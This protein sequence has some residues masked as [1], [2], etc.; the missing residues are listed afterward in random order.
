VI[1]A[2]LMAA[3]GAFY[4]LRIVKLMY[5][6]EPQ[7]TTP[8]VV[9]PDV[10]LVFSVNGLAMLVLGLMPQ[11]LMELCAYAVAHSLQ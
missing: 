9:Q 5:F 6:D 7:D 4:Y 10:A 3:V 11:R 8:I 2:V 1:F